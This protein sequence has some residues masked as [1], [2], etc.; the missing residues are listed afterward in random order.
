MVFKLCA[1]VKTNKPQHGVFDKTEIAD[2]P[3]DLSPNKE[4]VQTYVGLR[5]ILPNIREGDLLA[6]A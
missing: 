3:V 5:N 4:T 6:L 2:H 1:L